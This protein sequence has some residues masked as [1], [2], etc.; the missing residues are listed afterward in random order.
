[1]L[2]DSSVPWILLFLLLLYRLVAVEGKAGQVQHPIL[3]RID[4]DT[5][6]VTEYDAVKMSCKGVEKAEL[7]DRWSMGL[8]DRFVSGEVIII[9]H[10]TAILL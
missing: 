7:G 8:R 5:A 10:V 1:M 3:R 6:A 2:Q 9:S 4:N